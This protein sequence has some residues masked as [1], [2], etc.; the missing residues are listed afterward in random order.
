MRENKGKILKIAKYYVNITVEGCV[1]NPSSMATDVLNKK[2]MK[3]M[4]HNK[5]TG[6]QQNNLSLFKTLDGKTSDDLVTMFELDK[7]IPVKLDNLFNYCGINVLPTDFKTY[8]EIP[9]I[10]EML[11][12]KGLILGAVAVKDNKI[13]ILYKKGVSEHRQRFTVAHEL[14][15]CCLDAEELAVNGRVDF[16]LDIEGAT[17]ETTEGEYAANVF[18]GELLIPTKTLNLLYE[19]VK[20]PK[21]NILSQM[22]DVSENVMRARLKYLNFPF[23]ETT[24]D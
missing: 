2:R 10:S 12:K 16:R 4:A 21:L 8:E 20:T 19:V 5:T 1:D 15:H 13:N 23:V 22:F 17:E 9:E 14:A 24:S 7:M 3:K 11:N 18:A 6:V